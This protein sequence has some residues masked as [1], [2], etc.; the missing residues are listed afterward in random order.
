VLLVPHHGSKTSSG[1]GFLDALHP[2]FAV[3]SAGWRNRF[4]HPNPLVVER[5]ATAGIALANSAVDGAITV[6][7]PRDASP[8]IAVRERE[9]QRRYW[10]E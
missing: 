10:R 2:L 3:V 7:F 9:R 6:E 4:G 8:R 5:Y 1:A